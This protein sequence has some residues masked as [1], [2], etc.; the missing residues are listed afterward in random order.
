MLALLGLVAVLAGCGSSRDASAGEFPD[1]NVIRLYNDSP[2]EIYDIELSAGGTVTAL[3]RL[4][5]EHSP[6]SDR[7]VSPDP[8]TATVSWRAGD[9]GRFAREVPIRRDVPPKFRG[10]ILL[11]LTE[12]GDVAVQF[13][14]Y[15]QLR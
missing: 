10:V 14:P 12:A 9:G 2:V 11:R 1:Y 4:P 5:A 13:V 8:P 15:D 7:G 6:V 3:D